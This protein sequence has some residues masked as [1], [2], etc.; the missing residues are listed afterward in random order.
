MEDK[1]ERIQEI[2]KQIALLKAEKAQLNGAMNSFADLKDYFAEMLGSEDRYRSG[3]RHLC[4]R[5][6][7]AWDLL[8][9]LSIC[10]V[11][12]SNSRKYVKDLTMEEWKKS[13]ELLK[14][15]IDFYVENAENP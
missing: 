15:L 5:R 14:K 10:G 7:E 12:G 11:C 13:R 4:G 8:R 6:N 1:N 2:E 3:V 9:R